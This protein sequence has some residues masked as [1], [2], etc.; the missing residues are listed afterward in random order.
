MTARWSRLGFL[1]TVAI[2]CLVLWASPAAWAHDR[3]VG[4]DFGFADT[5]H[6]GP[7]ITSAPAFP[8]AQAWWAGTCD[9]SSNETANGGAGT[10]PAG[11]YAHC[12]DHPG[13]TGIAGDLGRDGSVPP[14]PPGLDS[15]VNPEGLPFDLTGWGAPPSWRLDPFAQAGGRADASASVWFRRGDR[16]SGIFGN[17]APDGDPRKLVVHLPAG[18]IGNPR[19]VAECP[20]GPNLFAIPIVCPPESQIGVVSVKLGI[21]P[22]YVVPVYNVEP[23]DGRT[24]EFGLSAGIGTYESNVFVRAKARTSGDF[25]V[26]ALALELPAGIPLWGQ[27]FTLWAVPWAAEHDRYRA[28]AG[29]QGTSLGSASVAGMPV[30][31][32]VGGVDSAGNSQEPQSYHPSWGDIRPFFANPTSDDDGGCESTEGPTTVVD[33]EM[34]QAPFTE[35][36]AGSQAPPVEGCDELEFG[37]EMVQSASTAADSPSGLSVRLDV[38]SNDDLPFPRPGNSAAQPVVDDYMEDAADYWDSPQGRARA[39]LK[40]TVVSMPEGFSLN[41]AGAA[42]L[43]A[44]TDAQLGVTDASSSPPLFNDLD[45]FDDSPAGGVECPDGSVV[46]TV[47]VTSPLIDETL[48]GQVVLGQPKSTNPM[49][50]QM[51]RMFLVV[52]NRERGLLAKIYGS[53]VADPATGRLTATFANG[54]RLPIGT[55]RLELKGGPRGLLATAPRCSAAGHGW[56]ALFTPWS[57]SSSDAP[58]PDGGVLPVVSNC[59]FGFAPGFSAGMS[60]SRAAS[61]GTFS[62]R[63]TRRDGEQ[64]LRSVSAKVPTGLLAAV[65]DVALCTDA[66]AAAG[67]CPASS[68]IGSADAGAGAGLPFFLEREGDVYLTDGYKGA[69]YGLAVKVPVEAGPFRGPLALSPI[70]VRQ[71]LHVDRTT[72]QVTAISDPL[73]QI[74]HGIP[75]R[76]RQIDVRVDRQGF[77][78]NPTG[79]S[80]KQISATLGSAEGGTAVVGSP[81]QAAGCREL[82]FKPKLTMRLTGPKRAMRTNGHPG[83]VARLTQPANQANIK[84]TVVRLPKPFVFDSK[85]EQR[86]GICEYRASLES[87]PDCPADT[88]IGKATAVSPLL[89]DPLR[90]KVIFAQDRRIDPDSGVERRTFPAL[91]IALRGEI[92]INLRAKTTTIVDKALV[93]EFPTIPDAPVTSFNLTLNRGRKGLLLITETATRRY[94]LCNMPKQKAQLDLD[95]HNGRRRDTNVTIKTPACDARAKRRNRR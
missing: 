65:G 21:L 19:A 36:S 41:P 75:L 60:T 38:E 62:L 91:V 83:L 68:R 5:T 17:I 22:A 39:H 15:H 86:R 7:P 58:L 66:Q 55:V 80:Q 78:R 85:Y 81:F 31:G 40:D 93:T 10:P 72:A 59:A 67:A 76:V 53:A 28:P 20:A 54:P 71:A 51:F 30:T 18:V 92:A 9:L 16:N 43:Q 34:W 26:D 74:H 2:G 77:M 56:S 90:G 45:P 3:S 24:A 47:S 27:T 23:R 61:S 4:A 35:I 89:K 79:C 87:E 33:S 14:L 94:N 8:D 52:R 6:I 64:T 13:G 32:L 63:I 57:A 50:G 29:Y 1:A 82:A 37:E 73:P 11:F 25:G 95:A 44:C 69:P 42:G 48:S 88:V 12:I 70:T 46:G 49:S 84:S